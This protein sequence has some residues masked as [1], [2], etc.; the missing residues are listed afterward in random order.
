MKI[1][2]LA[3]GLA[4]AGEQS[5]RMEALGA[6]G[7]ASSEVNHD[8]FLPLA[9]AA[10]QT[11]R[12]ELITSIAIA[13]ARNPMT[14]AVQARDLQDVSHG[15]FVL[16]LGSQV[17]PHITRRFSMPWSDPT[18]QMTDFVL[19]LRAI[20]ASW[21]D[22]TPLRYE[23]SHYQHTLMPPTMVP[24]PT[25]YADPRVV[26]GAVNPGMARVA[27]EVADGL[28][29]HGFTTP[30]WIQEV[31][32]PAIEEGLATSG[33]TRDD[34]EIS[35]PV[36]LATGPDSAAVEQSREV[37]RTT[38]AFYGS[39]PAYRPVLTLH[40]WEELGVELNLCTKQ[41]R[42][43]DMPALVSDEVLDEFSL[44]ASWDHLADE[45][46]ARHGSTLDRLMYAI[47]FD[48][49]PPDLVAELL[50]KLHAHDRRRA[51]TPA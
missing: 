27:G 38:I 19:A 4:S 32:L 10:G 47:P 1:D 37:I 51:H 35:C 40:G 48:Q 11:E 45:L 7:V 9:V 34:F 2:A 42:W 33:R 14:V 13:L 5:R 20:W 41:G 8:P 6:D 28:H 15:R 16:G 30:R 39:T 17:K 3:G 43:E 12:V 21:R 25:P 26:L 22:G 36:L 29:C 46:I 44:T 31:L 49:A 24:E 50:Q 23:G 18:Q